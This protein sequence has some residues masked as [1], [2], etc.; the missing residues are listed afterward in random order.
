[1]ASRCP[2]CGASANPRSEKLDLTIPAAGPQ[3][4]ARY[5]QLMDTNEPPA[6]AELAYAQAAESNTAAQLAG[7]D[8]EIA[9]LKS[10]LNQLEDERSVL[11]I[12]HQRSLPIVSPLRRMPPEILSEIFLWTLPSPADLAPGLPMLKTRWV[13]SQVSRRWRE[14]ALSTPSLWS[15]VSVSDERKADPLPMIQAQVQHARSLKIHFYGSDTGDTKAQTRSF[16]FLSEHSL[17]WEELFVRLIPGVVPLMST[18]RGRLPS[19]RRLSIVWGNAESQDGI[20]SI[21][22]FETASSLEDVGFASDFAYIPIPFPTGR[23]TSYRVEGPLEL[24]LG[25]LKMAPNIIEARVMVAYDLDQPWP[26]PS[27]PAIDMLHLKRL[28]VTHVEVLDH[29]RAPSLAEIAINLSSTD[30]NPVDHLDPFF[31]RSSCAPPRFCVEDSPGLS[32]TERILT[33][34]TFITSFTVLSDSVEVLNAHLSMFAKTPIAFPHLNEISFV[35]MD[36][37]SFHY[38]LVLEMLQSRR[39]AQSALSSAVFVTSKG[40]GPDPITCLALNA[41]R[42]A[43]MNILILENS[44]YWR[45][46][47]YESIWVI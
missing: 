30:E 19:L 44:D 14:V 46:L 21:K 24:H 32:I 33:K 40:P 23:L 8:E 25:V 5:L 2:T 31:L 11:A 3:T 22:C 12:S 42:E 39:S 10:R 37:P 36:P 15:L 16:A 1:M 45:R 18:L 41:L 13:L 7:L 35:S 27:D 38:P 17:R 20:E 29:L 6:A 47:N 4:I 34:F 9:Q 26:K 28:C 43:G